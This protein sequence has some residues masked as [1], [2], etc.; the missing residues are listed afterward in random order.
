MKQLAVFVVAGALV[1]ATGA[2]G[3]RPARS[4]EP[5]PFGLF[6]TVVT[7]EPFLVALHPA[8][9]ADLDGA[10]VREQGPVPSLR[11]AD[12]STVVPTHPSRTLAVLDGRTGAERTRF[13]PPFL[14]SPVALSRT[15]DRLVVALTWSWINPPRSDWYVFDTADGAQLSMVELEGAGQEQRW[16]DPDGRRLYRLFRPTAGAP[17]LAG[18]DL[19][20]GAEL[21]RLEL[22]EALAGSGPTVLQARD[23]RRFA[24]LHADGDAVV[25]VDAERLA[26][27]RVVSL[28]R[29]ASL[30]DRLPLGAR[31][32]EAKETI[33]GLHRGVLS[34]DG[35]ALYLWRQDL[36]AFAGG[37][38]HH[39]A[40]GSAGGGQYC[41]S[42]H[43]PRTGRP[44]ESPGPP[45]VA[46]EPKIG[47]IRA[48]LS[49]GGAVV[50]ALVGEAIG[51][52]E[53][54]PDGRSLYVTSGEAKL[55]RLDATTL[56]V[57][58]ARE[59]PGLRG[60]VVRPDPGAP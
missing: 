17:R 27:E 12:G 46:P 60:I 19:S 7:G 52:V 21:G 45:A 1:A 35:G 48:D 9:L 55:W 33:R 38:R 10:P 22:S 49:G 24:V 26:V 37:G 56:D 59:V 41:T 6:A 34:P 47:L 51:Q 31:V 13:E 23:G 39:G 8:T 58:A 53:P 11:S 50:R 3:A 20:T 30:W 44:P 40:G 5:V 25:L 2:D 18:H 16:V 54:T 14:A 36:Q 32:A 15:G 42:C 28:D 43:G 57:L 4:A 29:P